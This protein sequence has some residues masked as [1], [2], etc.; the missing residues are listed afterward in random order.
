MAIVRPWAAHLSTFVVG[1]TCYYGSK[2]G[3]TCNMDPQLVHFGMKSHQTVHFD[4][5][6]DEFLT[7]THIKL[8]VLYTLC[9]AVLISNGSQAHGASLDAGPLML[10]CGQ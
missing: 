6:V 7:Q 2:M 10:P 1:D 4:C 3:S 5:L 8:A 9:G